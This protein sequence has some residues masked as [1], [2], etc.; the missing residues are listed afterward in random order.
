[1]FVLSRKKQIKFRH[2]SDSRMVFDDGSYILSVLKSNYTLTLTFD[3]EDQDQI[4]T[5]MYDCVGVYIKINS[6]RLVVYV[7]S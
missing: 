5:P 4:L 6:L 1:M 3:L 2:S 7:I